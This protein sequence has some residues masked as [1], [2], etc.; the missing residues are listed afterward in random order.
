MK[1]AIPRNVGAHSPTKI[2]NR[3]AWAL[4]SGDAPFFIYQIEIDPT[5]DI[6]LKMNVIID[7]VFIF[8]LCTQAI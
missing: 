3:S 6:R 8:Y 2:P 7:S 5:T 1:M 4:S